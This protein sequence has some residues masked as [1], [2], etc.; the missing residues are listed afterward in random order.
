M[1]RQTTARVYEADA[2]RAELL[3]LFLELRKSN[4]WRAMAVHV[5]DVN[6]RPA[7]GVP[8]RERAS[9]IW[10]STKMAASLGNTMSPQYKAT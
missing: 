4:K 1:R 8:K 2:G 10:G 3:L 7:P 5:E 9:L 6:K